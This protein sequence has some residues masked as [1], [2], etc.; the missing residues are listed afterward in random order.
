ML[1]DRRHATIENRREAGRLQVALSEYLQN[2]RDEMTEVEIETV[3]LDISS[4]ADLAKN[5]NIRV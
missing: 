5:W 4:L 2:H 1:L 3:Q